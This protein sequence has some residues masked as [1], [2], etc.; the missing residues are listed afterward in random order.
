MKQ[1]RNF[2]PKNDPRKMV[3]LP[4][5]LHHRLKIEAAKAK[6]TLTQ[7]LVGLLENGKGKAA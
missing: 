2:S 6:L 5:E 3:I 4:E 1:K 7:Y